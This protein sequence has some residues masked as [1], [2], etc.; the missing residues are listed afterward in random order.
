MGLVS[1]GLGCS[2]DLQGFGGGHGGALGARCSARGTF[3]PH[4]GT[5]HESFSEIKG[6]VLRVLICNMMDPTVSDLAWGPLCSE[7]L[8]WIFAA[9]MTMFGSTIENTTN[10]GIM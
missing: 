5:S 7:H 1:K 9:H 8:I 3:W 6:P 2:W 10:L 4:V